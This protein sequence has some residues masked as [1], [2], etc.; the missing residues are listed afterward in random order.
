MAISAVVYPESPFFFA[1]VLSTV[2]SVQ[3][4]LPLLSCPAPGQT[5]HHA[6]RLSFAVTIYMGASRGGCRSTQREGGGVGRPRQ[7]KT[8]ADKKGRKNPTKIQE[9][10]VQEKASDKAGMQAGSYC[11][12]CGGGHHIP[13]EQTRRETKRTLCAQANASFSSLCPCHQH[14][15]FSGGYL[16]PVL[17][18]PALFCVYYPVLSFFPCPPRDIS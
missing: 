10:Q 11:C 12:V 1:S 13:A 8:Q 5:G 15:S 4:W 14:L 3:G 17:A 7:T 9:G 2:L 16:F 6:C 18:C